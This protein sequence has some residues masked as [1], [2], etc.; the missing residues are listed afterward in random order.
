MG[1]NGGLGGWGFASVKLPMKGDSPHSSFNEI[2][3]SL[4]H[5]TLAV[6]KA[7]DPEQIWADD[8]AST[9]CTS[10]TPSNF[11]EVDG[12]HEGISFWL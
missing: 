12:P 5:G 2:S 1:M 6:P 4:E 9:F 3:L 8:Q 11:S 7:V 10:T